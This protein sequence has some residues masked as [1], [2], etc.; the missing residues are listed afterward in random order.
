MNPIAPV[1]LTTGLWLSICIF[2][3]T[4]LYW[5][6]RRDKANGNAYADEE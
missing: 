2:Y 1:L 5:Q 4:L 3:G 6:S